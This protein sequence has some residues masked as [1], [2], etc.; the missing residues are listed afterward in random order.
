MLYLEEAL[1]AD[2]ASHSLLQILPGSSADLHVGHQL[3]QDL[4]TPPQCQIWLLIAD[5]KYQAKRVVQR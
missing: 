3:P 5:P 1:D 4:C 2:V